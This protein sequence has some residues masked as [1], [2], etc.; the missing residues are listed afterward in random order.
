LKQATAIT[1][2]NNLAVAQVETL[3]NANRVPL[4]TAIETYLEQKSG[5]SLKTIAH[6]LRLWPRWNTAAVSATQGSGDGQAHHCRR[7][8]SRIIRQRTE[9]SRP[10]PI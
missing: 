1:V 7:I 9:W 8:V 4:A 5:K 6:C 10:T 3:K 2:A